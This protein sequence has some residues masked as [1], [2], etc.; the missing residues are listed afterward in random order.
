MSNRVTTFSTSFPS[1]H[2]KKGEPTLFVEKI[3]FGLI[4][5]NYP[6]CGTELLKSEHVDI[7]N[8][9]NLEPKHHT[10]RAGSR[11]KAG[12]YLLPRIWTGKPYRSKQFQFAPALEVKSVWDFYLDEHKWKLYGDA[13]IETIA[14][15]DGLSIVDFLDWFRLAPGKSFEGQIITWNSK[16]NY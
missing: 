8:F 11:F 6:G 12:D 14:K 7:I 5:D 1:Y 2:P 15:N 16:I 3:L 10:I 13:D 4:K 9:Y